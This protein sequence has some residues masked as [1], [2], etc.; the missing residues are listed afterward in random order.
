MG[1]SGVCQGRQTRLGPAAESGSTQAIGMRGWRPGEGLQGVG[2][3]TS[4]SPSL[5]GHGSSGWADRQ[6]PGMC[7]EPRPHLVGSYSPISQVVQQKFSAAERPQLQ[8]KARAWSPS[9][10]THSWCPE[11]L[12]PSQQVLGGGRLARM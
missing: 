5:G 7:A 2:G 12:H 9:P 6:V 11:G 8:G 10:P 3:A 4:A 1:A